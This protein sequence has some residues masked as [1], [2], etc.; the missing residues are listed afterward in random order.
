MI[1]V[2]LVVMMLVFSGCA[3]DKTCPDGEQGCACAENDRCDP[4]STCASVGSDR[5]CVADDQTDI[6]VQ[7]TNA[8]DTQS[9]DTGGEDT[10]V[11]D[12]GSPDTGSGD[13]NSGDT[14]V[15]DTGSADTGSADTG[16]GDTQV[17]D[18]GTGDTGPMCGNDTIDTNEVCDNAE[19][20]TATCESELGFTPIPG[21]L[22]CINACQ[23]IDTAN[24][25]TTGLFGSAKFGS[26]TF[27][28]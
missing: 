4:G 15:A 8:P 12:T 19:F 16:T 28:S 24:C 6:V 22:A 21:T 23:S 17:A 14:G 11:A 2:A 25:D 1:R 27:G 26:H 3:A 13:T 5:I 10:S 7:D 9:D 20:G 18:T